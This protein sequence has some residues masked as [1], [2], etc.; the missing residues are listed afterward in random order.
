MRVLIPL[1]VGT[2][3]WPAATL[4]GVSRGWP[5][6]AAA[7]VLLGPAAAVAA[8]R[9]GN[10]GAA[11]LLLA[12]ALAVLLEGPLALLLRAG[13]PAGWGPLPPPR[14]DSL[15]AIPAAAWVVA[16]GGWALGQVRR[17]SEVEE[18]A[19]RDGLTGLL[20]RGPFEERLTGLL[21][22]LPPDT[23]LSVIMVDLDQFKRFNDRYGHPAGDAALRHTADLL[24][25][26]LPPDALAGPLRRRRVR[27]GPARGGTRPRPAT[28]PNGCGPPSSGAC[29]TT[30]ACC[31]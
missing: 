10:R 2:A 13:W 25:A 29:G 14:F 31:R 7:V 21:A 16:A 28:S 17:L 30:A 9:L 23:P 11:C 20:R 27:H 24:R 19:R 22:R 12:A 1:A 26:E 3:L 8:R 15:F 18:Q 5:S 6:G 4:L